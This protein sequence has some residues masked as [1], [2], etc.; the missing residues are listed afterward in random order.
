MNT[1]TCNG[2]AQCGRNPATGGWHSPERL[3]NPCEST[4]L[5]FHNS[6]LFDKNL[7]ILSFHISLSVC[8]DKNL[9]ILS[10]HNSLNNNTRQNPCESIT[11]RFHISLSV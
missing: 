11:L 5:S 3:Q 10:F 8:T 2:K 9:I 4:I 1:Y 6:L 7:I